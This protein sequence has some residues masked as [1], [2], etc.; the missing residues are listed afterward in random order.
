MR[1][2]GGALLV[3]ALALACGVA[4]AAQLRRMLE[5]P[6][7]WPGIALALAACLAVAWLVR[8]APAGLPRISA[9][10]VALLAAVLCVV[11][12]RTGRWPLQSDVG[13]P[14]GY[15]GASGYLRQTGLALGEI[16]R[17]WVQVLYPADAVA[18]P[19]AVAVVRLVG[20]LLALVAALA[21]I[22]YRSPLPAVLSVA[23][24]TA[25]GSLFLGLEP[26]RAR[27]PR[28]VRVR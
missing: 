19:D 12:L 22:A 20:L 7:G 5:P 17:A 21:L 6:E 27:T 4:V 23:V 2:V 9:S 14:D 25:V 28:R 26:V 10:A 11:G 3:T 15:L 18:E 24:A 1:R 8:I 16:G 13:G